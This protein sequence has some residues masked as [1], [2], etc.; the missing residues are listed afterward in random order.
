MKTLL[1]ALH[2][3]LA[4][5]RNLGF[6]LVD[7]EESL[8]NFLRFMESQRVTVITTDL[9]VQ[10]ATQPK[11]A[12]KVRHAHR[13]A[14]VRDFARYV[15]ATDPRTEV[16]PQ[17][18]LSVRYHRPQP[19]I[20]T[21]DEILQVIQQ[22]GHLQPWEG[23]RLRPVTYST[24]FGVLAV[25]GMRVS[26]VVALDRRDVDLDQEVIIIRESKFGKT[27]IVPVHG[28]AQERLRAYRNRRDALIGTE[29]TRSF[30]VSDRRA[31][32]TD[33]TV[34]YNF[35]TVAK[36]IGLR[37]AA[38][39]RRPRVHDLRHTFAVRT[40][41]NWY[42]GGGNPDR[43]LPLLSV[44]LGHAHISH[45]YWYLSAVPELLGAVKSRLEQFLGE[46]S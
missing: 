11:H 24:L 35:H 46:P 15:S 32:L 45:T 37:G 33:F 25:T 38:G 39:T 43:F 16:P 7:N 36:S 21:E 12:S 1:S 5:R 18:M 17:G 10:W 22:A 28:S 19:R 42:R 9:A 29:A 3:Y 26:E 30:F 31:R 23:I 27:R 6:A 20:Y 4:M 40:L 13:L 44:Y 8:L 41:A 34:R 2:Q 14:M